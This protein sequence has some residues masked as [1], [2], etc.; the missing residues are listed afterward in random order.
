MNMA[1]VAKWLTHRF[2]DPAFGGSI[3]SIAPLFLGISQAVRQRTL[4]PSCIGS[5]PI[6]PAICGRGSAV[7]HRLAKARVAG[8]IPV[9]RSKI[10]RHS[11]VVRHS[12]AKALSPVRIWVAPPVY[13]LKIYYN[14]ICRRGGMATRSTQNRV[15]N[16][17]GSSPLAGITHNPVDCLDNSQGYL[18]FWW[19]SQLM[20]RS[21][22]VVDV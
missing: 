2:V 10:W 9:V 6:S 19:F 5:N 17:G 16:R 20:N 8:S 18:L 21:I 15:G 12:S 4:T 22:Y 1:I 3:P 7:E 11:Q 14:M 13:L